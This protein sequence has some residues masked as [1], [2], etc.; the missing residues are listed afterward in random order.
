M[1][2]IAADWTGVLINF[3]NLAVN[4]LRLLGE[5]PVRRWFRQRSAQPTTGSGDTEMG[6]R[7]DLDEVRQSISRVSARVDSLDRVVRTPAPT[8]VPDPPGIIILPIFI[9]VPA[10]PPPPPT[11]VTDP[12][13]PSASSHCRYRSPSPSP[14]PFPFPRHLLL[15]PPP[16]PSRS[17]HSD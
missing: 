16:S 13:P 5:E 2:S 3:C 11:V 14:I 1:S 12:A 17:E 9:F 10:P 6:Q 8:A 15:F 7:G 4:V